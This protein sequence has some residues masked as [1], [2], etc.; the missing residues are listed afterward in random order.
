MAD[1]YKAPEYFSHEFNCPHCHVR[2]E[3]LWRQ[4]AFGPENSPVSLHNNQYVD[5]YVSVC[6]YPGYRRVALC[7]VG[8]P[9]CF[10]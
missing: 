8:P 9:L 5:F 3:Q 4:L 1:T 7:L 10:G 2:A 6:S